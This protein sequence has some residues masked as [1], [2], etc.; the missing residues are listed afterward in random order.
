MGKN[1]K[2]KQA[3][4][5]AEPAV[6]ADA[7]VN[8][9]QKDED[10]AV[11]ITFLGFY[12]TQ[13]MW[14]QTQP[15]L[16]LRLDA[17]R[18]QTSDIM[19]EVVIQFDNDDFLLWVTRDGAMMILLKQHVLDSAAKGKAWFSDCPTVSRYPVYGSRS[20]TA[21]GKEWSLYLDYLNCVHMLLAEARQ[22]MATLINHNLGDV[23][24]T[25]AMVFLCHFSAAGSP[26]CRPVNSHFT[27][28][29]DDGSSIVQ[30]T[31]LRT[32]IVHQRTHC[33]PILPTAVFDRMYE[34]M[35]TCDFSRVHDL[36]MI[37]KAIRSYQETSYEICFTLCWTIIEKMLSQR[38][39]ALIESKNQEDLQAER[40][41]RDQF[42]RQREEAIA[43]R[44]LTQPD[45][46]PSPV[47]PSDHKPRY[48]ADRQRFLEHWQLSYYI[49]ILDM[50]NLLPTHC[51]RLVDELR[52][53]RNAIVHN[54]GPC[55]DA[56]CEK[57]Y[58]IIKALIREDWKIQLPLLQMCP[59]LVIPRIKGMKVAAESS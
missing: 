21:S 26:I 59:M 17:T 27:W 47:P 23:N 18:E 56:D 8:S 1:R 38:W 13:A 14:V 28:R 43:A 16:Q 7:H 42:L 29:P 12:P 46:K 58:D 22:S 49:Q 31:I 33:S 4:V 25:N 3:A 57:A 11:P 10:V 35:R 53:V 24:M 50:F 51:F 32:S 20:E 2:K 54:G 48:P 37:A 45:W 39:T 19:H 52:T 30:N 9:E 34:Q 15:T 44:I 36:A 41:Q 40:L 55:R 6:N 5:V